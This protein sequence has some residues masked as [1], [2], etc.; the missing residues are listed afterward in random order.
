MTAELERQQALRHRAMADIAHE[1]RTPLS[2][3][4][5]ELES[6]EDGLTA[7]T[8]EVIAG[9]QMDV[10]HLRRLVEDLR[11]LSLVDAG[12]LQMD[13]DPVEMGG[14]V[15][16][17]IGRVGGAGRA[18]DIELITQLPDTPLPVVGDAQR[19]AQV[20][21]N[22]LSNALRHTPPGGQITVSAQRV[23]EREVQV[24]VRDTGEGI[25]AEELPP[26]FERLY[27]I[28]R[29]RNRDTGGSG[30]GL[31]ITRSLVEAQGGRIWAQS[32]R[33]QGSAFTF[34]LPLMTE[35]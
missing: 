22:L 12:E 17:V 7:P 25:P 29:A 27:R 23:E 6:I 24:T 20:L 16:D 14:L 32:T 15:Q 21:F 31:S 4:Q 5:I 13:A 11:T 18:K 28:D 1:L 2:V 35:G 26:V 19:L 33:G 8:P 9:L 3:L 30:L 10:A 34:V